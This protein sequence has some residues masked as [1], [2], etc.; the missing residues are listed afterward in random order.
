M[1]KLLLVV[2]TL[3]CFAGCTQYDDTEL[4]DSI[5]E[6]DKRLSAVEKVQNAYKNNL[7]ITSIVQIENGYT[8]TF[9][10]G[11]TATITNGADGKDG[12]NGTDG[13]AFFPSFSII[14]D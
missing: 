3:L 6:L 13:E 9:S 5:S 7:F 12:V 14:A 1:K 10:D 8:I 2:A 11:S 4:R